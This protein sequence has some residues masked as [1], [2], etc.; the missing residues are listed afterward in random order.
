[1]G[2]YVLLRWRGR[3]VETLWVARAEHGGLILAAKL[4]CLIE[5]VTNERITALT[6]EAELIGEWPPPPRPLLT[7][8]VCTRNR[9][10]LLQ[11][12]LAAL[13]AMRDGRADG[14]SGAIDLL[15]VDNVP[16]DDRTKAVAES[17][18]RVRYVVEARRGVNNAHNTSL[19]TAKGDVVVYVDDDMRPEPGWVDAL[20]RRFD[21]PEVGI[22]C[23]L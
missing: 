6:L 11:R 18:P 8:P 16:E 2:A 9:P 1:M 4:W 17:F 10:A 22:V 23:G 3:P 15:V 19:R 14:G 21:R 5:Q 20:L 7:T 12:C 13:V